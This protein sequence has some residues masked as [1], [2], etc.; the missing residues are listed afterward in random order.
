MAAYSMLRCVNRTAMALLDSAYLQTEVF[1]RSGVRGKKDD[2]R[3]VG[4]IST[5]IAAA[6]ITRVQFAGEDS[7]FVLA[8]ELFV[9]ISRAKFKRVQYALAGVC[10]GCRT[11]FA[12]MSLG[13]GIRVIATHLEKTHPTGKPREL[14]RYE[15]NISQPSGWVGYYTRTELTVRS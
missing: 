9:Y 3:D 5:R 8:L 6:K 11:V 2:G 1:C 15:F 10:S 4:L 13:L 14:F 12:P 7:C